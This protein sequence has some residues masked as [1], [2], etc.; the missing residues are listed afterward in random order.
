MNGDEL[1]GTATMKLPL[2]RTLVRSGSLLREER[3]VR[4]VANMAGQM[5]AKLIFWRI[6]HKIEL[7]EK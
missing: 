5:I 2:R 1:S 4:V 6:L 7:Y 3:I